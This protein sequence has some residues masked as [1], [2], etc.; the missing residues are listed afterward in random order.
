MLGL[1]ILQD[2]EG[3]Q[4]PHQVTYFQQE[5]HRSKTQIRLPRGANTST[6]SNKNPENKRRDL[7]PDVGPILF[8]TGCAEDIDV[9]RP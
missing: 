8:E 6:I 9:V 4:T 7:A 1:G 5:H 2:D 3:W